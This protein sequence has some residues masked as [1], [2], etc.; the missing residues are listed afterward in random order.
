M[1]PEY[2]GKPFDEQVRF[3]R[4]KHP[5]LTHAWTDVYAAEHDT[6]FMVAGAAKADLLNDLRAAVDKAIAGGTTLAEFRKDFDGIVAAHGWK[7]T[8]GR[9]WRTRVIYETN[10]RQSYMAGREAQMADPTL[11]RRRPYGLYR[12]GDSAHPR[13]QHLA[14]D[15]L[16]LP[17]DDPWWDTHTPQNGWGCKCKKFM[18]SAADVERMGLRVETEAPPVEWREVV[19]GEKGPNPRTVS[20][21]AGIDPGF[22]YR[23]GAARTSRLSRAVVEKALALSDEAAVAAARDLAGSDAFARW[24]AAPTG[25]FTLAVIPEADAAAIGAETRLV[26]M[27]EDTARKQADRHPEIGAGEYAA[28]QDAISRGRRIVEGLSILYVLE[29][30]DGYVTV[31]KSTRTGKTVFLTSFR[32]LSRDQ[33]KRDAELRRLL[34]KG[35]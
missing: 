31:V 33:V 16:V 19:V 2:G 34:R 5:E 22:E 8:G 3:F 10:V 11:R 17:L 4:K 35:K 14:W 18:V 1:T 28:A 21:P 27:S 23:P 26:E 30:A 7:H 12:H 24:L 32:R 15:G 25:T 20:V 9:N 13:R 6:A 29:D